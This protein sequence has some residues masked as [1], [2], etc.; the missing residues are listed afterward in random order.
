MNVVWSG[1][2]IR[3]LK[4]AVEFIGESS[5]QNA[6]LV[7]RRIHQEVEMLS[8]FPLLGLSSNGAQRREA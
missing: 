1:N 2:A 6:L 3:D 5:P 4:A 7:D 8:A